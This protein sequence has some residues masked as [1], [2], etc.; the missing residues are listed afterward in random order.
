[1][2]PPLVLSSCH[3]EI[4]STQ[5]TI[6]KWHF[7]AFYGRVVL[8]CRQSEIN[9]RPETIISLRLKLRIAGSCFPAGRPKP[10]SVRK[11]S[12]PGVSK[13]RPLFVLSCRRFETNPR[14]ETI[15]TG[16]SKLL[17]AG[18]LR[19]CSQRSANSIAS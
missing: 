5:E 16:F 6:S 10:T 8:S 14:R 3:F 2:L 19:A 15:T 12:S 13:L 18:T 1:L 4:V 11:R 7:E 17:D 9:F